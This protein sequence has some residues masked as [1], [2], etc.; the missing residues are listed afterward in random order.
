MNEAENVILDALSGDV[1]AIGEELLAVHD[2]VAAE[3]QRLEEA[4]ELKPMSLADLAEQRTAV[5]HVGVIPQYNK[6]EHQTGRT[7]MERFVINAK[8]AT[9]Q[10]AE[11]IEDVKKK[12]SAL[13]GYFGEDPQMATSDFFGTLRRFIVEFKKAT[14]QVE[15]IEKAAAKERKRAARAAEKAKAKGKKT[16]KEAGLSK[17]PGF[18]KKPGPG[19]IAALAAAAANKNATLDAGAP[20]G[21]AAM[22]A[23]AAAKKA[24]KKPGGG[25][26]AAMAAAAAAARTK[27]SLGGEMTGE[28][29][30]GRNEKR[31]PPGGI[32]TFAAE[33]ATALRNKKATASV[34]EPNYT[35]PNTDAFHNGKNSEREQD[36]K[37]GEP[38]V[39]RSTAAAS[40]FK[41]TSSDGKTYDEKGGPSNVD[42]TN[43]VEDPGDKSAF[44]AKAAAYRK[45]KEKKDDN[46]VNKEQSSEEEPRPVPEIANASDQ[47]QKRN[48]DSGANNCNNHPIDTKATQAK[49]GSPELGGR[50]SFMASAAAYRKK[51][52]M[53]DV[54]GDMKSPVQATRKSITATPLADNAPKL[55]EY[56]E[57]SSAYGDIK[58]PVQRRK[59]PTGTSLVDKTPKLGEYL[60]SSSAYRDTKSPVQRTKSPT[61]TSSVDKTPKL[62]EYLE[63]A[64]AY[65]DIK[66]PGRMRKS[67]TTSQFVDKIP[68]LGEFLESASA[69]FSP[70]RVASKVQNP[71]VQTALSFDSLNTKSTGAKPEGHLP[72]APALN[73]THPP[74]KPGRSFDSFFAEGEAEIDL[75]PNRIAHGGGGVL[76]DFD[77]S[78]VALTEEKRPIDARM[79][80]NW[81]KDDTIPNW[82]GWANQVIKASDTDSV[83]G[84]EE[85]MDLKDFDDESTIATFMDDATIASVTPAKV[86]ST[87]LFDDDE[88][89]IPSVTPAKVAASIL[90][91]DSPATSLDGTPS[92]SNVHRRP[93]DEL[94]L[95]DGLAFGAPEV[96]VLEGLSFGVDAGLDAG[97]SFGVD[98]FG[99]APPNADKANREQDEG[100]SSPLKV[101]RWFNW[102]NN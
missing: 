12:Y 67:S 26:I 28:D 37:T 100:S 54:Y 90:F 79:K 33:A 40:E 53:R 41:N 17:K 93:A 43:K 22:A 47:L 66:S 29:Q 3:A 58:S 48:S 31:S 35:A 86:A 13:L 50:S 36:A 75:T 63:S 101:P 27:E 88:D 34:G 14:E 87:I 91:N 84:F 51:K 25:G 74:V 98:E 71:G 62:G 46:E 16:S 9:D 61:A 24:T 68:K 57:S 49:K 65:G 42:Q 83:V 1:K 80:E 81:V 20:G 30:V 77:D 59:S 85:S 7:S 39:P 52:S 69:V 10:A 8:V 45:R 32:A 82:M 5:R 95:D 44:A 94:G 99:L 55:G 60:E 102:G 2:T 21:I 19:G 89:E 6:I 56:L 72:F 76:R 96:G 38:N 18:V 23:A 4:G 73:E 15:A 11:S 97:L 92:K 78:S 64:S 70:A